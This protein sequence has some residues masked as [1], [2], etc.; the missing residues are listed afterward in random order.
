M[1]DSFLQNEDAIHRYQNGP[2]TP[3]VGKMVVEQVPPGMQLKKE[4]IAPE[5][6]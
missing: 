5:L 4:V 1:L 6:F 3:S 2:M